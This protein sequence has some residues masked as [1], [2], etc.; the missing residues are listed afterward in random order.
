MS[1]TIRQQ[2]E[3]F[4]VIEQLGYELEGDGDHQWVLL[5]KTNMN[6]DM[7][8]RDIAKFAR[9]R[10][11]DVGFAGLKDRNAVTQQWFSIDLSGKETPDWSA[12]EEQQPL[13]RVIEVVRHR[14]K[15]KRGGL[16]SNRF[17]IR[18]LHTEMDKEMNKENGK[19]CIK[20]RVS[21]IQAQ[22]VPN[23]F[24]PQR[25]GHNGENVIKGLHALSAKKRSLDRHKR[26]IYLSAL[27]SFLFNQVLARR[28]SENTWTQ[29][30]PGDVLMLDGTNSIFV[31]QA[32]EADLQKR[33]DAF[34]VHVTGPLWGEGT[35]R[36]QDDVELVERAI[37]ADYSEVSELLQ[38]VRNLNQER[39]SLRLSV[40]DLV[41]HYE[42]NATTLS[43][44]LEKG[45]YA[46]SVLR[47]I[48]YFAQQ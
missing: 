30:S 45:A 33:L 37:A 43:F 41:A 19:A 27:R 1:A 25:F 24:G 40:K 7:L 34:D 10:S 13:I 31:P 44:E 6:T 32:D 20:E 16:H 12:F 35:L 48:F 18:V 8:A 36:T 22:G 42:E 28:V 15:L 39:R 5:E 4:Q 47:E 46:T 29:Y 9:V 23:Y 14:R 26:S 2:P 11:V 38:N 21:Q 17:V 3:D